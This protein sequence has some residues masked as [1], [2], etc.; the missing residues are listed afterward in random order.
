MLRCSGYTI[1]DYPEGTMN[2]Q[3]GVGIVTQVFVALGVIANVI[4][5]IMN[6]NAISKVHH[7]VDAVE[8][9]TNDMKDQLVTA[10]R[11]EAFTAGKVEQSLQPEPSKVTLSLPPADLVVS[12][13]PLRDPP[14]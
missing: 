6:S 2:L 5:N 8:H 4:Q 3:E 13:I 7:K 1:F 11:S 12:P 14:A 10:V 9:S